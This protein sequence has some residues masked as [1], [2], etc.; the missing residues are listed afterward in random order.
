MIPEFEPDTGN[1]PP[2]VHV[3]T[4][5]EIVA[6][7]GHTPWRRTLLAGFEQVVRALQGA[8]CRRV[9]LDGS[10]V[11]DK[12]RIR[13]EPPGDFDGCWDPTGV[14]PEVLLGL[15]P[16]LLHDTRWPRAVQK[17]TYHGEMFI[18]DWPADPVSGEAFLAYFQHDKQ[19]RAKGIIL[20]E[21]GGGV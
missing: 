7:L 8:G 19:G 13:G 14:D 12:E 10:F 11:T 6:R 16:S 2:G 9:Y 18:A 20:L 17:A 1:L 21:L 15:A 5:D 4:W 3:A